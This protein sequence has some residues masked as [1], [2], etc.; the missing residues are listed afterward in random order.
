MESDYVQAALSLLR[1]AGRMDLVRQEALPA[2][3]PVRKAAQGVAAAVMACSPLRAGV[4]P[5]QVRRGW[6]GRGW[7]S[8]GKRGRVVPRPAGPGK[9]LLVLTGKGRERALR[10]GRARRARGGSITLDRRTGRASGGWPKLIT[11]MD[12]TL[13]VDTPG[14]RWGG[15]GFAPASAAASWERRPGPSGVQAGVHKRRTVGTTAGELPR[16]AQEAL[17]YGNELWCEDNILDYDE[18]SIEEGE[19]VDDG[20][21]LIWWEQGGVGP[22]N[23]LSQSLQGI[24]DQPPARVQV[25][26]EGQRVRRKAQERPPSLPAG[27]EASV[28]MVLVALEVIDAK[29]LGATRLSKGVY[30]VGAGLARRG[31]QRRSR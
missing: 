3:R 11:R 10:A 21:E 29:G 27:E 26:E 28:T 1:K 14:E 19:L 17:G 24:Q 13:A 9:K 2:L 6:R 22:A 16:R 18:T 15:R 25:W 5:S 7:P 31:P 12:D 4:R 30:I 20:E 8:P 23:A